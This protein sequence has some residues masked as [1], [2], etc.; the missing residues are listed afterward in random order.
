MSNTPDREGFVEKLAAEF[1]DIYQQEA[2]RQ[3]D[4]RHHDDY[5]QLPENIKEFDRVLAR[6]VLALLVAEREKAYQRCE[7]CWYDS[8]KFLEGEALSKALE[9]FSKKLRT[10][11]VATIRKG[12]GR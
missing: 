10:E 11:E 2:K 9:F 8:I 5:D 6:Y 3:G 4:V 7:M 1:H 12:G